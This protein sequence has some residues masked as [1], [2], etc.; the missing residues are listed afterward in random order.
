MRN[1]LGIVDIV[2]EHNHIGRF[3]NLHLCTFDDQ[4]SHHIETCQLICGGNQLTGFYMMGTLVVKVLIKFAMINFT[5]SIDKFRLFRLEK[6]TWFCLISYTLIHKEKHFYFRKKKWN[7]HNF[8]ESKNL[9]NF[10]E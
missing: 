1:F 6:K 5:F 10:A 8:P 3:S 9:L 2:D 4:C 7:L